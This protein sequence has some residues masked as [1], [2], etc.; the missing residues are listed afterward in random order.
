MILLE[1]PSLYE[2]CY[3]FI[4]FDDNDE[5]Y[6]SGAK[7]RI[8]VYLIHSK[9]PTQKDRMLIYIENEQM[10]LDT[11]KIQEMIWQELAFTAPI[12]DFDIQFIKG[13]V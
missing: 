5:L 3:H 4:L 1:E 11:D 8:D 7:T 13:V 6:L 9:Y 12:S 2:N 10:S